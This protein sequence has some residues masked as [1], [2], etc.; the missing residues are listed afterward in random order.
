M[1]RN[2]LL[3][4]IVFLLGSQAHAFFGGA[5]CHNGIS[6]ITAEQAA[7][8]KKSITK[9]V[10]LQKEGAE[11]LK[12]ELLCYSSY[13][14]GA[15]GL[16]LLRHDY[17]AV[18][19]CTSAIYVDKQKI[20]IGS[21]D[22]KQ[23]KALKIS[24]NILK[25]AGFLRFSQIAGETYFFKSVEGIQAKDIALFFQIS[26]TSKYHPSKGIYFQKAQYQIY[27]VGKDYP[28]KTYQKPDFLSEGDT[29][30]MNYGTDLSEIDDMYEKLVNSEGRWYFDGKVGVLLKK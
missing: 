22:V 25:N 10:D 30:F 15:C 11:I 19:R 2:G 28:I 21:A 29:I 13:D 6:E 18:L 24:D 5:G 9:V 4:S 26:E 3:L 27:E 7:D 12:G 8:Y 14:Y 1:Y 16:N 20:K 23:K 17:R